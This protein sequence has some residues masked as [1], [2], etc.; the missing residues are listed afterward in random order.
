MCNIQCF[1]PTPPPQTPPP[2]TPSSLAWGG[3]KTQC[4]SLGIL[5]YSVAKPDSPFTFNIW[6]AVVRSCN[7][8][9]RVMSIGPYR[10]MQGMCHLSHGTVAQSLSMK[11]N[12]L[13]VYCFYYLIP[14][15]VLP[16]PMFGIGSRRCNKAFASRA[17]TRPCRRCTKLLFYRF[18]PNTVL[19]WLPFIATCYHVL[20]GIIRYYQALPRTYYYVHSERSFCISGRCLGLAVRY[21]K[22]VL[23]SR[24]ASPKHRPWS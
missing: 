8:I 11:S 20:L 15:T 4:Q 18:I 14:H 6:G 16:W 10:I 12:T 2:G 21:T 1:T 13:L 9:F 3:R 7:T 24:A 23:A 22:P 5:G 19:P 17:A